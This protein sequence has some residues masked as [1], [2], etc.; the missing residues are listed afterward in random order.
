MIRTVGFF[1]ELPSSWGFPIEGHM[2]DHVN[3]VAAAD[4]EKIVAY[5]RAGAGVWS[6]MSAGPDVLDF[7]APELS[8]IGSLFTDG[9]WLWRQDLAYY[10]A[11][12][13]LSL[14]PD[15]IQHVRNSD[16]RVPAVPE[17]RLREIF[18]E[19]LRMSLG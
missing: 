6:E 12:Y 19:D 14:D 7:E 18:T 11:K 15:F 9:R 17:E 16:Y 4:E 1:A 3:G 8:G 10:L 2:R 5:L 13:H